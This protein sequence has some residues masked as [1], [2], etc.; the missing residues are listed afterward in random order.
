MKTIETTAVIGDDRKLS[1]QLPEDVPPGEHRIVV[2]I[3]ERANDPGTV[4]VDDLPCHDANLVDSAFTVRRGEL[5]DH[6]GG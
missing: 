1:L 4:S 2:L 5:Y 3:E 6:D